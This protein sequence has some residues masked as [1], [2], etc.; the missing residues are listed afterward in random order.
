MA[1][2]SEILQQ[3]RERAHTG[4][5]AYSGALTPHEVMELMALA[6]GARMV[7]VRARAELDLCG[8]IPGSVHVEFQTYPGW[9]ANP[10]FLNQLR[11]QIDREALVL[12]ICRS[13]VRSHHAALAAFGAG[14]R[15]SYNVLEGFEG[16][17]DKTRR[18][19]NR[20]NGWKFH[21]LPW[22]QG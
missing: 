12:F 5:L 19:R 13:G 1:R 22:E 17:L 6:P 4:N 21:A 20:I 18:Q 7:D 8:T 9:Q 14:Y 11:Q 10:F 15:E 2:L 3:A 16:D